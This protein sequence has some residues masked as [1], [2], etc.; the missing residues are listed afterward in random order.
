[1]ESIR[2]PIIVTLAH[3]DHGKTTLLDKI[4]QTSVTEKEAGAI[5]QTISSTFVPKSVIE[6]ICGPL[7]KKFNVKITIPGLLWIDTPGHEAF[8]TMRQRGGSVADLAVLLIDIN[9]GVMPQTEESIQILKST[10][11]PFV[12]ALNKI[13]KISGWSSSEKCFLDNFKNQSDETK[14]YFERR[15][16]EI[17]DQLRNYDIHAERFDRISDFTKKVAAIPISAKTGEGI[18]ELLV[19]LAGLAQQFL[20]KKLI[21]TEQGRGFIL[22]VKEVVGLGKTID[23]V[24]HDGIVHK[25]DF[26]VIGGKNPKITKIRALLVPQPLKD[27]RVE[28]KFQNV[29]EVK[30]ACGV[31]ISAPDLDDVVAGSVIRTAKTMKEAEELLEEIKKEISDVEI[32]RKQEG[33]ILKADTIGSLEALIKIFEKYPIRI[34]AIGDITKENVIEAEANKDELFKIVIG[35]NVNIAEDAKKLAKDK[36]I[37][38]LQSDVIYRLVEGYEKWRNEKKNEIVKREIESV[39]RPGKIRILPNC[40]FRA[41]NPAIIGC[42]VVGGIIK[43]KYKLF[44]WKDGAKKVGEIKQIQSEGKDVGSAKAGDKVAVSIIGPTVGRQIKENDI[45]YTDISN[46]EYKK[47][48]KN[49]ELLSQSEKNVMEEIV[50]MKRKEDPK[51]GL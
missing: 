18:P 13:D 21:T 11:T 20:K 40:I 1:M 8:T 9:E 36:K 7:L 45:L 12:I 10:K 44:V 17:I 2:S 3:V 34:A 22:E 6:N 28:K 49:E 43:P 47:L 15:F 23:V 4:R 39:T 41:S 30:A 27:M 33:L 37:T 32:E 51:F 48:K 19:M 42:E 35:F 46:E 26:L 14:G 25:N 5:T 50:E 38:I 31:K 29:D 16:Y 24:I